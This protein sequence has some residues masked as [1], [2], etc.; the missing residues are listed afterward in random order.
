MI[1]RVGVVQMVSSA[2]IE[3][4]LSVVHGFFRDAEELKV[5]LL[6]LPEN[7]AYMGKSE[8][9]KLQVAEHEGSGPIQD[10]IS[11]LA[12]QHNIWVIAGTIALKTRGR[13]I[14]ASSLVFDGQGQMVA[15]YDKIHLFDVSVSATEAHQESA[16]IEP[17][18][19]PV[20]VDTPLGRVGLSVCYDLRFPELYQ[21]YLDKG[22]QILSVPSAFT[23]VTGKAHWQTLLKARA[24]ENLSYVLAPN[25]GG[26]HESGRQTYGHSMIIEPWGHVMSIVQ[27]GRGMIVSDIDL[28]KQLQLRRQFPCHEHHVLN[29]VTL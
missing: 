2:N 28:N 15:R 6:V 26:L 19:K 21:L 5:D 29:K 11:K 22:V 18:N 16:V 8:A 3:D 12:K 24:I 17:G 9:D 20:I 25:Q 13:R 23:A 4:N 1:N 7:F 10:A 27:E 14:R